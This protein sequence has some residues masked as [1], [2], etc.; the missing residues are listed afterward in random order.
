MLTMSQS[1]RIVVLGGRGLIGSRL[2]DLLRENAH[3][4]VAASRATGVDA[5]TGKG[6]SKALLGA[7]VVVD[8]SDTREIEGEGP[9]AFFEGVSRNLVA[10]EIDADV[11]HHIA[12]SIVGVDRVDSSYFRAKLAQEAIIQASPVPYSIVRST[13]FFELVQRML[14]TGSPQGDV[15]LPPA[16]VQPVASDDVAETLAG[17]AT[18][19][20]LSGT[21]ELAGPETL[22]LSEL[23]RL[24]LS[25]REDP[26]HVIADPTALY[27]GAVLDYQALLPGSDAH[28]T[29]A[30]FGDWLRQNMTAD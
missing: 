16:L 9:L 15:H 17:I 10:A 18:D 5:S 4:V 13:Q 8:V 22:P 20:P 24:M 27:F 7:D 28:I 30:T 2:V 25:A 23:A 12:L 6:L 26:R 19:P 29:A 21:V 3:E 11:H 14:Q 1:M